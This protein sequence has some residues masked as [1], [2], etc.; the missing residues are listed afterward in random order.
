MEQMLFVHQRSV[1]RLLVYWFLP[2]YKDT[3][4]QLSKDFL[5]VDSHFSHFVDKNVFI[6][7]L[8]EDAEHSL[9]QF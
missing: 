4:D 2:D 3:L 8:E 6:V 5:F 9:E 1:W 7:S